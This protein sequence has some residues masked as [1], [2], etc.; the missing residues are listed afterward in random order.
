[1]SMCAPLVEPCCA[2][3]IEVLTRNSS[4]ES[5]GGVGKAW[6]TARYGEAELWSGAAVVLERLAEPPSP[7][8]L[9]TRADATELVLLPLKRL[10]ASTPLSWNVLLVSRWPLAQTGLLPRPLLTPVLPASSELTPG[11]RT[12]RPVKLPVGSGTDSI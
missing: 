6:P 7:V 5:G 4:M 2:S 1:M 3:Y 12:A 10:L 9:T 8:L 11:E